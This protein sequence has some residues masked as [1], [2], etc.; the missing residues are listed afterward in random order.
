MLSYAEFL[1]PSAYFDKIILLDIK[2]RR[3]FHSIYH[4][5]TYKK[6]NKDKV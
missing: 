5:T 4:Y 1:Y 2:F 3:I 6:K